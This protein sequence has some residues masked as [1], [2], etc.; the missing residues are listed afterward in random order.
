MCFETSGNHEPEGLE[1]APLPGDKGIRIKFSNTVNKIAVSP[2][3]DITSWEIVEAED[4]NGKFKTITGPSY[5]QGA[6]GPVGNGL[7]EVELTVTS[8][9]SFTLEGF[10]SSLSKPITCWVQNFFDRS[11]YLA[12]NLQDFTNPKRSVAPVLSPIAPLFPSV[13]LLPN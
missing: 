4:N 13:K 3:V 5:S 1:A 8:A 12:D 7:W 2:N 11:P 10:G 6:G 9:G